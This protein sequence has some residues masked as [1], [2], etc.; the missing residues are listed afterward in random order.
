MPPLPIAGAAPV[1]FDDHVADLLV[2]ELEQLA[3][4]L[5]SLAL[6]SSDGAGAARHDWRGFTR[7]W[8]DREHEALVS[9][10][11]SCAGDALRCAERVR[12]AKA[13]AA[14]RQN[15]LN[16]EALVREA[17]ERRRAALVEAISTP[18]P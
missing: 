17:D 1:S 13:D 2:R 5:C 11:R 4:S 18:S 7:T 16:A 10:F 3:R 6:T 15:Q 9:D 12:Q 8:F 14:V